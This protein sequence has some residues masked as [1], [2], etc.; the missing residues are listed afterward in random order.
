METQFDDRK[1]YILMDNPKLSIA[2]GDY[3]HT[4]P[5]KNGSVISEQF[6][7][8]HRE[9]K[10]VISIFRRMVRGLEFDISEMA[11]STYFCARAHGKAFTGLPIF[12]TRSFYHEGLSYN[13]KS[14]IRSV[15]DLAGKRVG[16]R[17]Y[18]VTPGVWT[19]G[20]LETV[21]GVDLQSVTWVLSGDEHVAEYIPPENVI[22]SPNSNL[23]E[24]LISGEID[25]AIGAGPIESPDVKMLFHNPQEADEQWFRDTGLYP[26]SHMLVVKNDVLDKYPWL[27]GS[28]FELF[29]RARN[30]YLE[31]LKSGTNFSKADFGMLQFQKIVGGDPIQYG[32][33]TSRKTLETFIDFNVRQQVIP[34][35]VSVEELFAP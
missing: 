33:E 20:L 12:L 35:H 26:I 25:A 4:E 22:S 18:T 31:F 19:R 11:L 6:N 27:S 28:L 32:V 5:L 14:G 9:I 8:D 7:L 1:S 24:M 17:G 21:Y 34:D 30:E 15:A 13:S 10:P 29:D 23:M 16:V 3:G 2:V